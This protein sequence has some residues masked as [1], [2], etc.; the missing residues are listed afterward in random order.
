LLL[1]VFVA[2]IHAAERP[3]PNILF[4]LTEDQGPHA[5][6]CG[7]PGV[8]TPN[9]DRIARDG[10]LFTQAYVSYPVCS[11]SKAA[12][13]TGLHA[14]TKRRLPVWSFREKSATMGP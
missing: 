7:T 1:I 14:H 11:A 9:I 5:G 6:V 4:I 2:A 13:Y 10:M 8:K 12:F 3:R